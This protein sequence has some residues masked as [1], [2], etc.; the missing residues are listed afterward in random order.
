MIDMLLEEEFNILKSLKIKED[1]NHY[2]I[3]VV[4]ILIKKKFVRQNVDG[5]YIITDKGLAELNKYKVDNAIIMAAGMS[6]RFVPL[7]YE[8]PKGLLVVKGEKLIERQIKQLKDAGINDITIVVGYLKEQF[9]YLEEKF[10]VRIVVNDDYYR[11]NNTSSL[12]RVLDKINNTYI[13][14]SDNYFTENVFEEYVYKSY[15]AAVFSDKYT[16]E[17]CLNFDENNIITSVDIGDANKWY[18]LGHAYFD[19]AFSAKFKEI[20]KEEYKKL[21]T[22]EE[23]WE[24]LYIRYVKEL[25]LHIKKY[26]SGII[27]EFDSLKELQDFDIDYL[28]NTNS[29][30]IKN[31]CS[32]LKCQV[33]EIKEIDVLK[34]GMTNMSFVFSVN[35]IKYVYRHPGIGTE[36]YI[37]RM[38]EAKSI[39]YA[40]ELGL[41]KTCIFMDENVGWKISYFID[42]A[43][44]PD[45]KNWGEVSK[46]INLIKKLHD[47]DI[48]VDYKFD[49]WQSIENFISKIRDNGFDNFDGFYDLYKE[50]KEI[51][52]YVEKDTY[53]KCLCHCDCFEPNFL[54]T[55]KS[56]NLIDWEYSG[57][58]DPGVDL[59]TFICCSDYNYDEAI[60][61]LK[62]YFGR[63]PTVEEERHFI[64]YICIMS[65]YW[66]LWAIYQECNGKNVDEYLHLWFNCIKYYRK[67]I[68]RRY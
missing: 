45:L 18:M 5:D 59:G 43:H 51:Y 55:D 32:V 42:G 16:D 67:K 35:N 56:I 33:S 30:I 25:P 46:C 27:Y 21:R 8:R 17:Y 15:Y 62:L 19:K 12:I 9:F 65:Y 11:Y 6:S 44:T 66:Y 34:T 31:I 49:V 13:C 28:T 54:I 48:Q 10:D 52:Q 2:D 36:E 41:D 53:H 58:D 68:N 47:A 40:K 3:R 50:V 60:E 64:G 7:S 20:L 29:E 14:S 22:R 1:I 57:Y 63:N 37:D 26:S 61:I 24:N 38:N 4:N 39:K 23:L